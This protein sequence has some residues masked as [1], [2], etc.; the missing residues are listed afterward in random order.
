VK[1]ALCFFGLVGGRVTKTGN[2]EDLDP[3]IAYEYYKKH[4]L[5]MNDQVDVF[6]HSWSYNSKDRLIELYKPKKACIE[7]QIDYQKEVKNFNNKFPAY[8]SK[9]KLI[10]FKIFNKNAYIKLINLKDKELFRAYSRW[11]SSKK[12]LDLK[13]EYENENGFKYDAV[14]ITRLDVGFFSELVFDKYDMKYFYA[15]HRNGAPRKSSN[16]KADY[17]NYDEGN[18]FLDLWF[19]SNSDNMDKFSLLYDYIENYGVSPHRSS[20][21]HVDKFIGKDKVKYTMYRWFDHELI[22][23]KLFRSND[24]D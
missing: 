18:T 3:T 13:K 17:L 5:D 2:G 1:V 4:L 21:Q 20:R 24:S 23:R 19:F 10:F 8:R 7:N 16:Y 11:H 22:R 9:L 14:M 12:S 6:I 15:S